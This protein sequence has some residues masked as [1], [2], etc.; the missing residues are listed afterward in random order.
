MMISEKEVFMSARALIDKLGLKGASENAAQRI[1]HLQTVG[2][3]EGV[4]VWRRIRRALL[5]VSG[6]RFRDDTRH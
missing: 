5:D 2:D 3:D 1:A 6:I 4:D